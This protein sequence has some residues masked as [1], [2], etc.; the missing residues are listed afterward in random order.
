MGVRGQDQLPPEW[1]PIVEN[2]TWVMSDGW[3]LVQNPDPIEEAIVQAHANGRTTVFDPGPLLHRVPDERIA[4]VLAATTVLLLTEEEAVRLVRSGSPGPLTKA[5]LAR[6]PSLV[7]LKRGVEGA[8]IATPSAS[9]VQPAFP[10]TVRDTT[11]A[12][13]AFDAAFIA[14]LAFGMSASSA[15]ALAGGP[16]AAAG[17]N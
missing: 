3:V 4:R 12:G 8:L 15:A 9:F 10:V 5:L 13:D 16:R 2:A 7:A 11:G 1:Q 17:A 14:G 6:G